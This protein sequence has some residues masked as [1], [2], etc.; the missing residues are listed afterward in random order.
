MCFWKKKFLIPSESFYHQVDRLIFQQYEI[1]A[2]GSVFNLISIEEF[3]ISL[4]LFSYSGL[5]ITTVTFPLSADKMTMILLSCFRWRKV[6]KTPLVFLLGG[7]TRCNSL[8][9]SILIFSATSLGEFLKPLSTLT[10][11]SSLQILAGAMAKFPPFAT[12]VVHLQISFC[13]INLPLS[14]PGNSE[15]GFVQKF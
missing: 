6:L 8:D 12:P 9:V 10:I 3:S 11:T 1:R 15:F 2:V 4:I 13:Q 14:S 5:R 7:L